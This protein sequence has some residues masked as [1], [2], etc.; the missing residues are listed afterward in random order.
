SHPNP[1]R[2]QKDNKKEN[3]NPEPL[4][5]AGQYVASRGCLSS[6]DFVRIEHENNHRN[7]ESNQLLRELPKK[8]GDDQKDA[9]DRFNGYQSCF[10]YQ[11]S[12]NANWNWRGS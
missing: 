5:N 6:S 1:D 9:T 2:D 8:P 3:R 11:L 7:D 4:S 10:P 12:R